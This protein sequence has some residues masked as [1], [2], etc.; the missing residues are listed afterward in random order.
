MEYHTLN[1][2]EPQMCCIQYVVLFHTFAAD[3]KGKKENHHEKKKAVN[4]KSSCHRYSYYN[5][6]YKS[7]Y[8]HIT[9]G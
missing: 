5:S 2:G 1:S 9:F 6:C 4:E 7:C 3:C 8:I